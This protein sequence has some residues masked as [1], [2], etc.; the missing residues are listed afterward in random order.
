MIDRLSHYKMAIRL[1]HGRFYTYM[2]QLRTKMLHEYFL[3]L[4]YSKLAA[5]SDNN[6]PIGRTR[7]ADLAVLSAALLP[8]DEEG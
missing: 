1:I 5:P 6:R 4:I 7:S 8:D 3:S 2:G